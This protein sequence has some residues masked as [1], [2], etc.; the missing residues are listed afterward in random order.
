MD[1]KLYFPVILIYIYFPDDLK[2]KSF[3][4]TRDNIT[5][6]ISLS[7]LPLYQWLICNFSPTI[8]RLWTSGTQLS[9][10]LWPTS[11]RL[12]W[13]HRNSWTC[14]WSVRTRSKHVS[15]LASTPRCQ[16]GSPLLCSTP[17]RSW[18]DSA[19]SPWATCW[20]P[21]LTSGRTGLK[22]LLDLKGRGCF[23]IF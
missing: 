6:W 21:S 3:L 11:G 22:I 5:N 2:L 7:C 9:L 18:V 13:T 23:F 17:L 19:C 1:V 12:W 4:R 10:A 16:V 8:F 20:S 15:R 14:W